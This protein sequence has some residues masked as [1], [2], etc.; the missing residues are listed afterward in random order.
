MEAEVSDFHESSK[1]SHPG[2][3]RQGQQQ[4]AL[5][6]V[7]QRP[8]TDEHR[9]DAQV[10]TTL[11]THA[12]QAGAPSPAPSVAPTRDGVGPADLLQDGAGDGIDV[13]AKI[14]LLDAVD[15]AREEL[16]QVRNGAV[17]VET[18]CA[19]VTAKVT[20]AREAVEQLWAEH[21][22]PITGD[23][24]PTDY[25]GA[26][27]YEMDAV[28]AASL[29]LVQ[30]ADSK[31]G[32]AGRGASA[33]ALSGEISSLTVSAALLG[34][35]PPHNL[36][37][38][39]GRVAVACPPGSNREGKRDCDLPETKR[40]GLRNR[41]LVRLDGMLIDFKT[42]CDN[43]KDALVAVIEKEAK[44]AEMVTDVLLTALA[45][46]G[47][48]AIAGVATAATSKALSRI[49]DAIRD[50]AKGAAGEVVDAS[51][52]ASA[53]DP[54]QRTVGALDALEGAMARA[55]DE[56]P[57]EPL[58][59]LNDDELNALEGHI[60]DTGRRMPAAVH[61]FVTAYRQQVEPLDTRDYNDPRNAVVETRAV[62]I[63][64]GLKAPRLA[65]VKGVTHR[66]LGNAVGALEAWATSTEMPVDECDFVAWVEPRFHAIVAP[67]ASA[68]V[69][70]DRV[71][72]LDGGEKGS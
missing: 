34:Y 2:Q 20:S 46:T 1:Q 31:S 8:P 18:A 24:G 17:D 47:V 64:D 16:N 13:H 50:G 38:A 14:T 54:R 40:E 45:A 68:L 32:A 28:L 44:W 57:V 9:L 7:G 22:A 37:E 10:R 65:V 52:K 59:R 11:N 58:E 72:G 60:Q 30:I 23:G 36:A 61:R 51:G 70:P 53:G 19:R 33:T 62:W 42:A 26:I 49:G 55:V 43:E 25:W 21:E 66:T 27:V 5:Q 4:A 67:R 63:I 69:P 71:K 6:S 3:G 29:E 15:A 56:F 35:D 12:A 41:I 48:G 39:T